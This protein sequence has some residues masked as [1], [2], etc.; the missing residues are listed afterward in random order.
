MILE[1]T[2]PKYAE[3]IQTL[4]TNDGVS[5]V[6]NLCDADIE[7]EISIVNSYHR[8]RS[9][10]Q[11]SLADFRELLKELCS[12]TKEVQEMTQNQKVAVI[13]SGDEINKLKLSEKKNS[14]W[15]GYIRS[16]EKKFSCPADDSR[17][18]LVQNEVKAILNHLSLDTLNKEPIQGLVVGNV[19]SGKTTNMEGLISAAADSGWNFFIILTGMVDSLRVQTKDRLEGSL[20]KQESRFTWTFWDKLSTNKGDKNL[21][22]FDLV[23]EKRNVYVYC[24]LKHSVVLT[25]LYKCLEKD[26]NKKAQLKV[27]IIDD[28]ADQA[29]INTE[30]VDTNERTKI[31]EM[32]S[33]ILGKDN[34]NNSHYKA[35]NYIGYTATPYPNLLNDS[36]LKSLYPKDFIVCLS[37]PSDYLGPK[38][39]FGPQEKLN[40][41]R[42]ISDEDIKRINDSYQNDDNDE[43]PESLKRALCWFFC[44]VAAMRFKGHKKPVSMLVNTD[45]KIS[46][47]EKISKV[48]LGWFA[49]A[50]KKAIIDVC[51]ELWEEETRLY[52]K[53]DFEQR[54][55]S[56]SLDR[57]DDYPRFSDIRNELDALLQKTIKTEVDCPGG[58]DNPY[59]KKNVY[60]LVDNS[61]NN[62]SKD[63]E[64]EKRLIYPKES[65]FAV[66][67]IVIGGNT[68]SRGITIEGLVS[69]Y[70]ARTSQQADT[71][72]QMGRW[73]GY[74]HGYELY[75]RVWMS[76]A[77]NAKFGY[78]QL[79]DAELRES[80]RTMF[81]MGYAP[82]NYAVQVLNT[83]AALGVKITSIKKMQ[84]AEYVDINYQ[85]F[86]TKTLAFDL[87]PCVIEQN[88]KL[89][90]DLFKQLTR[91]KRHQSAIG[92][93]YYWEAVDHKYIVKFLKQ[94]NLYSGLKISS[95]RDALCEW[96]EKESTEGKLKPWDVILPDRKGNGDNANLEHWDIMS[97]VSVI[98][99]TRCIT[100]DDATNQQFVHIKNTMMADELLLDADYHNLPEDVTQQVTA[101]VKSS[102]S[103]VVIRKCRELIGKADVP[104]LLLYK[105]QLRAG[106]KDNNST[107]NY[108]YVLSFCLL[109]PGVDS[110]TKYSS[111]VQVKL[112]NKDVDW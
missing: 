53:V 8:I 54:M 51:E 14:C 32:I 84:K 95:N 17:I 44:S 1:D 68:L 85:G 81:T 100:D 46:E 36:S 33:K 31:Y 59:F 111:K 69:S 83:S 2:Y 86:V 74:R 66:A 70:F 27:L 23:E 20:K 19:Q 108:P 40:V 41:V 4:I 65:S 5:T 73:F 92:L 64:T 35:M 28:E 48:I 76:K 29:S 12:R 109:I 91:P 10:E 87:D 22:D 24:C 57:I 49:N 39:F 107:F 103:G 13:A 62:T 43:I 79:L 6:E 21:S 26:P 75:P 15:Q 82:I 77:V 93:S 71:L 104:L 3:R 112:E 99:S 61:A 63:S 50:Q 7:K 101:N 60:L 42:Y 98:P 16:L 90:N 18:A 94:I 11:I 72:M 102:K 96:I 110:Y 37:T 25:K 38:Q 67:V 47:H 97:D 105:V 34:E 45:H 55:P 106:E 9:E 80:I 88:F 30:D 78:I 58:K 89:A 52:R 56:Y